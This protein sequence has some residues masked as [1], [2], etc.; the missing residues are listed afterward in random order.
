MLLSVAADDMKNLPDLMVN[1][2]ALSRV[3]YLKI[4]WCE[5]KGV[6]KNRS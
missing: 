5:I 4:E 2:E 3:K 6:V 1:F